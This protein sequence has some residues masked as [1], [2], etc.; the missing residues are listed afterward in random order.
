MVFESPA[1]S[2]VDER[3]EPGS[4]DVDHDQQ[5]DDAIHRHGPGECPVDD[6]EIVE[7]VFHPVENTIEQKIAIENQLGDLSEL[8]FRKF[9]PALLSLDMFEAPDAAKGKPVLPKPVFQRPVTEI[10]AMFLAFDPFVTEGFLP[11]FP[12]Q[13]ARGL[14]ER[15]NDTLVMTRLVGICGSGANAS[16][17]ESKGRAH[18]APF[19]RPSNRLNPSK[20]NDALIL[21][22]PEIPLCL[23]NGPHRS[24]HDLDVHTHQNKGWR[25]GVK[26][27]FPFFQSM[28]NGVNTAIFADLECLV[29]DFGANR[30]QSTEV[31]QNALVGRPEGKLHIVLSLRQL[32]IGSSLAMADRP[33][34]Q[35]T[36]C[37]APV[38]PRVKEAY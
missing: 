9:F 20:S 15:F 30:W 6:F 11:T 1:N 35:R 16:Q 31:I 28:R 7:T 27:R 32:V 2:L 14:V 17:T 3:F 34:P 37:L 38:R 22:Q 18:A 8:V 10:A 4:V 25:R 33:V 26:T 19:E 13:T 12:T 24:H 21:R 36:A 5:I 23:D 29:A